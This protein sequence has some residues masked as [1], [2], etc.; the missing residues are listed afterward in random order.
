MHVGYSLT[1][2]DVVAVR[3]RLPQ[4][5][6]VVPARIQVDNCSKFSSKVLGR[7]VYDQRVTLDFSRPGKP[8]ANLCS[9]SSNGSFQ[10]ECL[11][12]HGF[13]SLTVAQEKI[14]YWRQEYN[15]FQHIVH[16]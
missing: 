4:Q 1:G 10:D 7:G 5:I 12:G 3:Q 16:C 13:R 6:G 2:E 11:N 8:T 9:E 15:G 14:E